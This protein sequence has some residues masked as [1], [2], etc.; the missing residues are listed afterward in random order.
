[1]KNTVPSFTID[2]I[3]VTFPSVSLHT[4]LGVKNWTYSKFRHYVPNYQKTFHKINDYYYQIQ[5]I[6]TGVREICA[7]DSAH[8]C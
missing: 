8:V 4:G 1:M 2:V 6:L 5:K 7:D 3:C